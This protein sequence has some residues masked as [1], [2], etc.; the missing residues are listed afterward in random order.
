MASITIDVPDA[1]A[2]RCLDAV[3]AATGWTAGSGFTKAQWAKKIIAAYLKT[4]IT[5]Y[6]VRQAVSTQEQTSNSEIDIS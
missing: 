3:A 1:I 2:P 4:L 6:E 5:Q